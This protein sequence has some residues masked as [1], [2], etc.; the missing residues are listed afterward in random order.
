MLRY[1]LTFG[2][3]LLTPLS[4]LGQVSS[5]SDIDRKLDS[6]STSIQDCTAT[7][8]IF[9]LYYKNVFSFGS[10]DPARAIEVAAELLEFAELKNNE[11]AVADMYNHIG[12]IY[13]GNG[14][15]ENAIENH[16][17]ATEIF[18]EL[19]E[20][21][22]YVYGLINIG[23]IF[24]DIEYYED[25]EEY[26]K[27][28]ISV[29]SDEFDLRAAHAVAYNNL[30]LV[31]E[32]RG[33]KST[34]KSYYVTALSLRKDFGEEELIIHSY[35]QFGALHSYFEEYDSSLT[36]Y[37]EA[38]NRTH[39]LIDDE[40]IVMERFWNLYQLTA[41]SYFELGEYP[42]AMAYLDSAMT[43]ATTI[44]FTNYEA[45]TCIL[46]SKLFDELGNEEM[47]YM[48]A[49]EAY[50][51]SNTYELWAIKSDVLE[52]LIEYDL[53]QSD[54][55]SAFGRQEELIELHDFLE[56][57]ASNIEIASKRY[58]LELQELMRQAEDNDQI[59]ALQEEALMK[60]RQINTVLYIFLFS[61]TV[62]LVILGYLL[63]Q[64]RKKRMQA[65]ADNRLIIEQKTEIELTN[66]QLKR[67]NE[68]LEESLKEKSTF[69]SKMSHE[70]RTPMNAIGGLTE[71]LLQ[72]NLS[73]D[74]E[75]LVR[76]INHS[77]MRLTALVDDILDYS[78]LEAGR[79]ELSPEN[80]NLHELVEDIAALN[81]KRAQLNSSIVHLRI[82]TSLPKTLYGDASKL[83]Q[84]LNNLVSNAVK[85]TE[86]G[87]VQIRVHEDEKSPKGYR[88]NFEIEDSG[89]GISEEALP[90]IF[91]EFHQ[92]NNDIHSRFGG[93]GLGLAICKQLVEL[94][95]G[96][97]SVQSKMGKGSTFAF[98]VPLEN[99]KEEVKREQKEL[100]SL[101]GRRLLLVED[102]KMNQFVAQR[103]LRPS[104]IEVVIA[105]DG[106]EA[107]ELC[108]RESFDIILMDIQMPVMNGFD[109]TKEI[110]KMR[111]Y[112]EIP[113]VALTADVQGETKEKALKTGMNDVLTKP[114]Q[115]AELI[116]KISELIQP[117]QV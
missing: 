47:A 112:K 109:S 60:N 20:T 115:G 37:L 62:F 58:E 28:A 45:Q 103:I 42:K 11:K 53:K 65:A 61:F 54:Y 75:Q 33:N 105:N 83:Q 32:E 97:I 27:K 52:L 89:I 88:V 23:N 107:I 40:I 26:Y 22:S 90:N 55:Q 99:A 12:N 18:G 8:E 3:L 39:H 87:H 106:T 1:L 44:G 48:K 96:S 81:R 19:N 13:R 30:G 70:I 77:S 94:M 71:V 51:V 16:L 73:A 114:F 64:A 72:H 49:Q 9:E 29:E 82:A 35:Q 67:T 76:N 84:I 43:I 46:A 34:A 98:S 15:D 69:M 93:T 80:F 5:Y 68:L 91:D 85:F 14:L 113:I 41:E 116:E 4:T 50:E 86:Q 79:V 38:L 7:N 74:Q 95:G 31:E 59:R 110:R 6:I 10:R 111:Q 2:V 21:G 66:Q 57:E 24:F 117:A 36:Y 63:A 100:T 108:K 102:D 56:G 92:G 17:I 25:A 101:D 104:N 78:R